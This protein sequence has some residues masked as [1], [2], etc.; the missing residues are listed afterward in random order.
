MDKGA[1]TDKSGTASAM[2]GGEEATVE[3]KGDAKI[4][5]DVDA[6]TSGDVNKDAGVAS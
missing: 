6:G 5:A 3:R 4:N 2:K 1:D